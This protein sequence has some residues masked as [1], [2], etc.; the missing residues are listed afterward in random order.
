MS[1]ALNDAFANAMLRP[2]ERA[3]LPEVMAV[4]LLAYPHPWEVQVMETCLQTGHY[5]GW[6]LEISGKIQGYLFLSVAAGEVHILNICIHPDRQGN[7]WG[8]ELLQR[9]FELAIN[10][11]QASI[12]FLEVRPSNASALALYESEGFNEI[13][14]RKNYYPANN[15]REDALVMAKSIIA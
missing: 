12:C 6:V 4:E 7:G 2:M 13:G 10:E 3:D 11:Y 15:G 14:M 8:R 9:V 5:H 1:E